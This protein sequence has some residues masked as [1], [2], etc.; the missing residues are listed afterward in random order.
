M[1]L[2]R[3]DRVCEAS[4]TTGTG[5]FSLSGAVDGFRTFGSVM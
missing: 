2:I 4:T 1:T 5:T 3:A